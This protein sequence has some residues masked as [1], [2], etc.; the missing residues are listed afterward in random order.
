MYRGGE[1]PRIFR[2]DHSKHEVYQQQYE[3]IEG[4]DSRLLRH[5]VCVWVDF[6]LGN[7]FGHAACWPSVCVVRAICRGV[8]GCVRRRCCAVSISGGGH[9]CCAGGIY[10][11][12]IPQHLSLSGRRCR[13]L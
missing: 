7:Y 3:Y 10:I 6:H 11:L 9:V 1:R 4:P 13:R 8:A 5:P 12:Y 2:V